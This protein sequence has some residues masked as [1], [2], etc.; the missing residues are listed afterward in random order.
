[1]APE[2]G[3]ERFFV[4]ETSFELPPDFATTELQLHLETFV[5]LVKTRHTEGDEV[6]RSSKLEETV[7]I[8][9]VLLCD[10]IYKKVASIPI[11]HDLRMALQQALNRCVAWD[12]HF[13]P[14]PATSVVVNGVEC[15][16][17]TIALVCSRVSEGKGSACLT[18]GVRHDRSQRALVQIGSSA[19]DVHFVSTAAQ[20]PAFYR[21]LFELEDMQAD[22]YM[23]NAVDAFPDL[24]FVPGLASQMSRFS[25]RFREVRVIVSAHLT[26]LNDCFHE[27]YRRHHGNPSETSREFSST[28]S[29]DASPEG[30][31]THANRSA[32]K[33]RD[34]VIDQVFVGRRSFLVGMTVTCEWHTKIKPMT[35]RIHFH[36]GLGGGDGDTNRNTEKPAQGKL[37]IGKF[38]AHLSL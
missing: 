18:L 1:M 8:S 25:T 33:E 12:D 35:D 13:A 5:K 2:A 22:A 36:P 14:T 24:A 32:M 10:L 11:D 16:A 4:D 27:I 9:A 30:P 15:V 7:V 26:A 3:S 37:I 21:S 19:H 38:A 31:R 28:C 17:A 20:V 34:V 29:V 6:F 23:M